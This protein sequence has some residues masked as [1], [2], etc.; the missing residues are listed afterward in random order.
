V[1]L[2]IMSYKASEGSAQ[3]AM[4]EIDKLKCTRT[5]SVRMRVLD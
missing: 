3:A 2:V 1:P 4:A 5:G